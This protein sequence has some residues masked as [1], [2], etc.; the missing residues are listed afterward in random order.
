M[1]FQALGNSDPLQLREAAAVVA[2]DQLLVE[3][4]APFLTPHPYRGRPNSPRLLPLTVHGLAA[5]IGVH[6]DE[7]CAAVAETGRRVF[8]IKLR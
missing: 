1:S 7:L 4:D 2:V 8:G 5:A 6:P 3:T